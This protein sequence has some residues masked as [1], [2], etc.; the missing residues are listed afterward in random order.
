MYYCCSS[1]SNYN[2]LIIQFLLL[3]NWYSLQYTAFSLFSMIDFQEGRFSIPLT[4]NFIIFSHYLF[5]SIHGNIYQ[6]FFSVD[7]DLSPVLHQ[8]NENNL[9]ILF[10]VMITDVEGA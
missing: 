3:V 10:P 8:N 7:L 2:V 9:T 5:F 6:G 4:L 1:E